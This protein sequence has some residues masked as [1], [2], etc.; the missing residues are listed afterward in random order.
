MELYNPRNIDSSIK[1]KVRPTSSKYRLTWSRFNT[2]SELSSSHKNKHV[3]GN[4]EYGQIFLEKGFP[5]F[6]ELYPYTS[7]TEITQ[8]NPVSRATESTRKRSITNNANVNVVRV[9]AGQDR[10]VI[11]LVDSNFS[12]VSNQAYLLDGVI[13]V[14]EVYL[15]PLGLDFGLTFNDRMFWEDT[16]DDFSV[17]KYFVNSGTDTGDATNWYVNP[18]YVHGNDRPHLYDTRVNMYSGARL[19]KEAF[20][21]KVFVKVYMNTPLHHSDIYSQQT[22]DKKYYNNGLYEMYE[23]ELVDTFK[24][25]TENEDDPKL[26]ILKY[27]SDVLKVRRNNPYS[28]DNLVL[29]LSP[30]YEKGRIWDSIISEWVS[31]KDLDID[32]IITV[33]EHTSKL[34][35]EILGIDVGG[36]TSE[37]LSSIDYLRKSKLTQYEVLQTYDPTNFGY[38]S[39]G[40]INIFEPVED[41]EQDKMYS[42]PLA[43]GQRIE[44]QLPHN[45]PIGMSRFSKA[46]AWQT[47]DETHFDTSN[48]TYVIVP[49]PRL[50]VSHDTRPFGFAKKI[51]LSDKLTF[52]APISHG[53][54]VF[55]D[56]STEG[57]ETYSYVNAI[58]RQMFWYLS[59]MKVAATTAPAG[60]NTQ[61]IQYHW[62]S[63][64]TVR[65][66]H[67]VTQDDCQFLPSVAD[68]NSITRGVMPTGWGTSHGKNPYGADPDAYGGK[69]LRPFS[70][71]VGYKGIIADD[72]TQDCLGEGNTHYTPESL[73]A[74]EQDNFL[75]LLRMSE[76]R[77]YWS[78]T[79]YDDIYPSSTVVDK[80][81]DHPSNAAWDR[82]YNDNTSVVLGDS[83]DTPERL[84]YFLRNDTKA[85]DTY[86]TGDVEN[87]A[88]VVLPWEDIMWV[89]SKETSNILSWEYQTEKN[90]IEVVVN[91]TGH[92]GWTNT[93]NIDDFMALIATGDLIRMSNVPFVAPLYL[94]R[95]L[96]LFPDFN[97]VIYELHDSDYIDLITAFISGSWNT[98][99]A[100]GS[101][102][103][104]SN[105]LIKFFDFWHDESDI[106]T[107][108]ETNSQYYTTEAWGTTRSNGCY[109]FFIAL[110]Q[111]YLWK[112][113]KDSI[114][115]RISDS[116][117][118]IERSTV[119]VSGRAVKFEVNP[120][121][122]TW[123]PHAE[124]PDRVIAGNWG[125]KYKTYFY[126]HLDPSDSAF[127]A[128]VS[129]QSDK[130]VGSRE[131]YSTLFPFSME[132]LDEMF[133]YLDRWNT[134][135]WQ[136][137]DIPNLHSGWEFPVQS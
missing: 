47:V 36:G 116:I 76:F 77:W 9:L 55:D 3:H 34:Q 44:G 79:G 64:F 82:V 35:P 1:Q 128:I 39:K 60:S 107:L 127:H 30:F 16:D 69:S 52:Y 7:Y 99:L 90:R 40:Q 98:T 109:G 71:Q 20:D 134:E 41:Q 19:Y 23:L 22:I 57:N 92:A 17:L 73:T 114:Y 102:S 62:S 97:K 121:G 137:L 111:Y 100:D 124:H 117:R 113:Y 78:P 24:D 95:D 13:D 126:N 136:K 101:Q 38:F 32:V 54:V 46:Q 122:G 66:P 6:G 119:Q 12:D 120:N 26:G 96:K 14:D 15:S 86:Y 112:Y 103:L 81:Y 135:D 61:T 131:G 85:S 83:R 68:L 8:Y 4:N 29:H 21:V 42:F 50:N 72:V 87:L 27:T 132:A 88:S 49:A 43:G 123:Y 56:D 53:P 125:N 67:Q 31:V 65:N 118:L 89:Y 2:I 110:W 129:A 75:N 11:T 33:G 25:L 5:T 70:Y 28:T 84:D 93:N 130:S 108:I 45:A 48:S 59:R 51:A 80:K 10:S 105:H 133:K 58:A 63:A 91:F 104:M 94:R 106:S 37:T 115:S 18:F 74:Y